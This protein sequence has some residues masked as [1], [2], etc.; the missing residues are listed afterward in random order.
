MTH[1]E[2]IW[3]CDECGGEQ[4]RHDMW[5]GGVCEKCHGE[6]ENRFVNLILI[7]IFK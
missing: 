3:Y 6:K 1:E 2:D 4:G 5:F 7:C